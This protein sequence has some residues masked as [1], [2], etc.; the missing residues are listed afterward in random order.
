MP[1][2]VPILA[3]HL[4]GSPVEGVD[5]E[6]S[7]QLRQLVVRGQLTLAAVRAAVELGIAD[8]IGGD[9]RAS[10][11]LAQELGADRLSLYRLLRA[12]TVPL[13]VEELPS[14]RFRLLP[15]GQSL[16]TDRPGSVAP[17]VRLILGPYRAR[18][19]EMLDQGVLSGRVPA[20]MA[21]GVPF[22]DYLAGHPE[23]AA[24]F[25]AAMTSGSAVLARQTLE[26]YD[27]SSVR[28]LADVGGGHGMFLASILSA[29]PDLH[30]I[31]YDL[32]QVV[33]DAP[34]VLRS[35]GVADRCEVIAGNFFERVPPGADVYLLR[36]ILHDWNDERAI[37]ILRNVRRA[38]PANGRV[39]VVDSLV[40]EGTGP[41]VEKLYDLSMLVVLGGRERT[42][43]EMAGIYRQADFRLSRVV[44]MPDAWALFEGIPT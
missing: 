24:I 28:T 40:P 17:F 31:L 12:L 39:V 20:E 7:L 34:S 27:L 16:R 29:R 32:P 37:Q 9:T 42:E 36:Q 18:A 25:N 22:F 26:A 11:D 33:Q 8:R 4:G 14:R 19:L 38:V 44:R 6:P 1:V 43:S 35:K 30:G 5:P 2:R 21:H 3:Q 41:D 13:I 10:D 23:E 15:M